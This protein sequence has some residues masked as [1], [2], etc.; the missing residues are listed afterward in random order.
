RMKLPQLILGGLAAIVVLA[1]VAVGGWWFFIREDAQLATNAPAIPADL[2]TP[3]ATS[4]ANATPASGATTT[5]G[6][7]LTFTI[8]PDRSEAAYFADEKL[9][10]LPLPSTA[11]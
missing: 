7:A 11:K 5:T 9:A 2:K 3:S 6:G 1:A 8:L 10:A 4:A